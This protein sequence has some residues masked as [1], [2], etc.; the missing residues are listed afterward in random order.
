MTMK[1]NLYLLY[2]ISFLQGMVF[3]GSASVLY[4]QEAGLTIFQIS[5]IESI[6]LFL[7]LGLEIPWGILADKIG[8]KKTMVLCS[9]SYFLS[10]II[11][12][13]AW[14]FWDFLM[15][16]I[17]LSLAVSGLSGVD[18]SLLYLSAS[19]GRYQKVFGFYQG[20]GQAG[21]FLASL[22]F[23][24][25]GGAQLRTAAFLTSLAYGGALFLCFLLLEPDRLPQKVSQRARETKEVN[26]VGNKSSVSSLFSD[27]KD[28]LSR[29]TLLLF[30]TG[31]GLLT[32]TGQMLT[33]FLN[34]PQYMACGLSLRSI[35]F[36]FLLAQAVGTIAPLS[37]FFCEKLGKLKFTACCFLFPSI[38]C[39]MLG[40][41]KS[42][43]CS[44]VCILGI[45]CFLSLF[46]PLFSELQ[47]RAVHGANRASILSIQAIFLELTGA[48]I[49]PVLG[50]LADKSLPLAFTAGGLFCCLGF[51]LF[52]FIL[53][54]GFLRQR[55][56]KLRRPLK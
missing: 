7:C 23:F 14:S 26:E 4:R 52:R 38:F 13:K 18:S 33:V 45:Q 9:L 35:S 30:L 3:Y 47:N 46:Q 25:T 56:H 12:W 34:Q 1:K 42:P 16:R 53:P 43:V 20:L 28:V 41:T 8:Y 37:S 6:S 2:G 15:E 49:N 51:F 31:A 21:L 10:K 22:Y 40:H 19:E 48:V 5:I 44:V 50:K 29:K 27:I 17:F 32:E 11:F 54:S 24:F 36:I 55:T 39:F